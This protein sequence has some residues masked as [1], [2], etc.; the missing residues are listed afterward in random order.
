MSMKAIQQIIFDQSQNN[1]SNA[2][3]FIIPPNYKSQ[4]KHIKRLTL[5][6]NVQKISQITVTSTLQ[7]KGFASICTKIL[8]Q[9]VVKIGNKLW[10]PKLS[11]R[12]EGL[13]VMLIGI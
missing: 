3:W 12:L 2:F 9:M 8:L 13:G 10:V 7:K 11:S 5:K 6:A 1:N 4:Y